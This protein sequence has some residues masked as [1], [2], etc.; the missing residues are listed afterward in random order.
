MKSLSLAFI[1]ALS[2]TAGFLAGAQHEVRT[3]SSYIQS[4]NLGGK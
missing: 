3:H 4:L 1:I 2:L